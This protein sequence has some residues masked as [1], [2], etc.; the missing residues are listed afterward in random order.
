MIEF[1]YF[2]YIYILM[3]TLVYIYIMYK[4]SGNNRQIFHGQVERI[5]LSRK[6]LYHFVSFPNS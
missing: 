1:I 6:V 5:K 3:Y 2:M 4:V